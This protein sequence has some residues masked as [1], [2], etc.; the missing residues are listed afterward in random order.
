MQKNA[1]SEIYCSRKTQ[2][3]EGSLITID[4]LT[5][6]WDSESNEMGITTSNSKK[7]NIWETSFKV[8]TTL[9]AR[10][11]LGTS[12]EARLLRIKHI[13]VLQ[14]WMSKNKKSIAI[15]AKYLHL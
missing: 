5:F 14:K 1:H 2:V 4:L 13:I 9:P 6:C 10:S 11:I 7:Y 12:N 8:V 3:A 15:L